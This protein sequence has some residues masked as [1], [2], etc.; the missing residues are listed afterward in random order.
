M[1]YILA[2][3]LLTIALAP[4]SAAFAGDAGHGQK[5]FQEECSDCHSVMTGKN[6]KGPS[7][8]NV[9]GRKSATIADF[10]YSDAMKA[11]NIEWSIET[12]AEYIKAPKKSVPGGK[13]KYDGL[14]DAKARE[15][16]VA[17]LA[18]LK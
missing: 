18:T 16:V 2:T 6:K 17:F 7:L 13:M 10:N 3:T 9:V 15:D 12:I 14:D 8:F 1:K 4:C 5:V 11:K